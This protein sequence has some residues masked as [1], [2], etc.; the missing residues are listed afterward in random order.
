MRLRD[1][2]PMFADVIEERYDERYPADPASGRDSSISRATAVRCRLA[3]KGTISAR[4]GTTGDARELH[5][6]LRGCGR[7]DMCSMADGSGDAPQRATLRA[8]VFYRA[9]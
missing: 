3:M 6:R 8:V 4:W 7:R 5:R 2:E 1:S 9:A